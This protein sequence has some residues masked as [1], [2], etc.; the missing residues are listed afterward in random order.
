[1][2]FPKFAVLVVVC[3]LMQPLSAAAGGGGEQIP[4][5]PRGV[6]EYTEGEVIVNGDPA[7][8]GQ[9]I[10]LGAVVQTGESSLCISNIMS[11]NPSPLMS[12]ITLILSLSILPPSGDMPIRGS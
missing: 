8:I 2:N 7:E 1:M 4:L 6:V 12:W 9:E 3:T 5:N 10:D 11:R